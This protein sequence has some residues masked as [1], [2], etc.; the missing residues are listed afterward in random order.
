MMIEKLMKF[1]I[2]PLIII[3][4]YSLY[5]SKLLKNRD[6]LDN[7]DESENKTLEYLDKQFYLFQHRWKV[8]C[9]FVH[10]YLVSPACGA[11]CADQA[12]LCRSGLLCTALLQSAQV[13][14]FLV[15]KQ[16]PLARACVAHTELS[17]EN[18]TNSGPVVPNPKHFTGSTC[19]T[20]N[21]DI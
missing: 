6:A 7:L 21:N 20:C 9:I 19:T 3:K 13:E 11:R 1:S 14:Q 18:G 2:Q 4:V 12:R 10:H 17:G 15:F 5:F 16:S 8:A